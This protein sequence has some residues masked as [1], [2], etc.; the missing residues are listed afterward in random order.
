MLYVGVDAHRSSSQI[1]VVDER[2]HV[3]KR[4]RVPSTGAGVRSALGRYRQPL[5]SVLEAS[6][7]WG[8]MYDW[9]DEVSQ[10]V[11]LA[12][13]A[14]VRAIAEARIKTDKI[15]SEML[16]HLLRADLI[17][18]AYAPSR[19]VRAVKRV[20]RQRLF[21]VRVRT[22][23]KNRVTALLAQHGIER[24]AVS[25]LFGRK[26]LAWLQGVDLPWP[27]DRLLA[28]DL[29]L[30]EVLNARIASTEDL[31]RDLAE[32]DEAVGW[33]KSV[34]GIGKFFS[35][36]VRYEVDAITRFR[37]PKKFA[38][39]TG[40]VPSTYASGDRQVHGRLTKQGNK[41][42]RWALVEAVTPAI[43]HSPWLRRYYERIKRRRGAK[44]ART[45]TARKLAELIWTVW[46]EGRC[47]REP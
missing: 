36:L 33:L 37:S 24:P 46:T 5:K 3:L 8:P 9:L 28:E 21:L 31:I 23:L 44:D 26:G 32:G 6:Y 29:D 22:M 41:H 42:L 47:Y 18:E 43:C 40:L 10:E 7:C 12:H 15:D 27:D 1:T 4:K 34:P 25:D 17:P 39:Y 11:I 35:V 20:L 30:V 38:S 2:G 45:A 14:K 16:A 19:E 13:P